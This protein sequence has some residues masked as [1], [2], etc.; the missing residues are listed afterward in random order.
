MFADY[1]TILYVSN[2][3][4]FIK[5]YLSVLGDFS[6]YLSIPMVVEGREG[7]DGDGR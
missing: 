6:L 1:G 2:H 7:R 3:F 5:K 4:I